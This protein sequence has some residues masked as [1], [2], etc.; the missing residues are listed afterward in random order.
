MRRFRRYAALGA[1]LALTTVAIPDSGSQEITT[2][3]VKVERAKAVDHPAHVVWILAMGS[4][5]RPGERVT[6]S[7]A[8]AIQLVGLN[9]DTGHGVTFGVPRDS[10]VSIPGHGSSRVNAALYFGGPQLMARTVGAMFG[11][12]VD[13]AFVTGFNGLSDMVNRIGGVT[14]QSRLAFS[15]D[16]LPG[17]FRKGKNRVMGPMAVN[18]GRMRHFLPAGDF[19]RSANQGLLI[20][21]IARKV[22]ASQNKPGFIESALVTVAKSMSTDLSPVELYRLAQAATEI[23]PGKL[24]ACVLRGS[25]GN[26]GG[27]SIVHPDLGQARRLGNETRR[28]ATLKGGC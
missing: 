13:Y 22:H 28:D 11:V 12:D 17:R 27:A 21:A 20:Q 2:S 25:I 4:D 26:V 9:L 18:F 7:R 14:V 8:D 6:R 23:D 15:D 16:N 10:W 3:L 24:K 5:A 1:V 19:D